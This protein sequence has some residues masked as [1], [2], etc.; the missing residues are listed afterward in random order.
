MSECD[1]REPD[2]AAGDDQTVSMVD[3]LYDEQQLQQDA[4]AVLGAC[5]DS[6]CTYLQVQLFTSAVAYYFFDGNID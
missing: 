6:V 3:V 2:V 4:D 1:G 5:D